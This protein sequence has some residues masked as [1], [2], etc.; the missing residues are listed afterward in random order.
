MGPGQL[1]T[2]NKVAKPVRSANMIA[3]SKPEGW[4]GAAYVSSTETPQRAEEAGGMKSDIFKGKI[5][6]GGVGKTTLKSPKAEAMP[7]GL[8]DGGKY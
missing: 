4:A 2:W 5:G 1:G 3:E 7:K 6:R 8:M